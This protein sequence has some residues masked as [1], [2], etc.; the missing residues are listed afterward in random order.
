MDTTSDQTMI[1]YKYHQ[2]KM[3]LWQ[4]ALHEENGKKHQAS[5][6][7]AWVAGFLSANRRSS[8]EI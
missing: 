2:L 4:A 8:N 3:L 7:R 1:D 6:I 5:K